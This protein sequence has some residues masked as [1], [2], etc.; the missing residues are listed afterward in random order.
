MTTPSEYYCVPGDRLC[1]ADVVL[2]GPGTYERQN[3][4]YASIAGEI[5]LTT[6]DQSNVKPTIS[7]VRRDR[8]LAIPS[9]G[10]L[11]YCKVTQVSSR[12]IRCIIFAINNQPMKT[13][14]HGQINRENIDS[15]NRDSIICSDKFR[16]DDIILARSSS[17]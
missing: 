15:V 1:A 3:F 4:I 11:A 2:S 13:I 10:A 12:R 16:P 5:S 14:S 17:I 7:V 8:T 6:T 9:V